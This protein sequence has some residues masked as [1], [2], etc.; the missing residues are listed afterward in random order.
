[1]SHYKPQAN[2]ITGRVIAFF[3]ANPDEE[4]SP[5]DIATKFG[6]GQ[7]SVHSL[8]RPALEAK[9]LMRR[10]DELGDYC[11][12]RG[13]ALDLAPPEADNPPPKAD[14]R[15]AGDGLDMDAVHATRTAAPEP[16]AK[17]R[18]NKALPDFDL[19]AIQVDTHIP[20][21]ARVGVRGRDKWAPLFDKLANQGDS[22]ALPAIFVP[23]LMA[24][25]AKRNRAAGKPLYRLSKTGPEQ[26]RVW[27]VA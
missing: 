5:Y 19:T 25:I 22:T 27:R 21:T 14:K 20:Y 11:Y 17:R 10:R 4:L 24:A 6:A 9:L 8:L 1:M 7:A 26:A 15:G 2:S 3:A 18:E 16:A 12:G 23:A 13:A